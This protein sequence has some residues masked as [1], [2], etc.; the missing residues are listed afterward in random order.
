MTPDQER[1]AL[2][3]GVHPHS[4]TVRPVTRAEAIQLATD[5]AT[6]R[7]VPEVRELAAL[8]CSL[9]THPYGDI[10][11]WWGLHLVVDLIERADRVV[12]FDPAEQLVIVVDGERLHFELAPAQDLLLGAA[13]AEAT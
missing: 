8:W 6:T 3:E 12:V 10:S 5:A 13:Y 11:P 7:R 1:A 4:G 9:G 2:A